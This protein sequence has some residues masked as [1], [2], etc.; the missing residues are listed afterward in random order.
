[1]NQGGGTEEDI[2]RTEPATEVHEAPAPAPPA[3]KPRLRFVR[4]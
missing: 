3:V 2:E 1:M 4:V